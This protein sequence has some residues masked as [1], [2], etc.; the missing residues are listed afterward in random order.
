[1]SLADTMQQRYPEYRPK[2]SVTL[3]HPTNCPI[4]VV[5]SP[6]QE[7]KVHTGKYITYGDEVMT[8]RMEEYFDQVIFDVWGIKRENAL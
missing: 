5:I 8:K 2:I 1:M 4:T 6:D 3:E 7:T